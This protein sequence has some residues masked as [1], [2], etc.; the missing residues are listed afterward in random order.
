MSL[1][2]AAPPLINNINYGQQLPSDPQARGC[3]PKRRNSTVPCDDTPHSW[4]G[5][6]SHVL[7]V[8]HQRKQVGKLRTRVISRGDIPHHRHRTPN[9]SPRVVERSLVPVAR[10]NDL[11]TSATA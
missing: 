1:D 4:I 8:V 5:G 7:G 11:H 2:G 3:P 6:D 10:V 9:A